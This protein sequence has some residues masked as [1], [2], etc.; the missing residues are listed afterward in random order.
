MRSTQF[1]AA[2]L[3]IDKAIEEIKLNTKCGYIW[4][5]VKGKKGCIFEL[6]GRN[7]EN[8]LQLKAYIPKFENG[9][10]IMLSNGIIDSD[11]GI[12]E[13]QIE[14]PTK[15]CKLPENFDLVKFLKA[16]DFR[17]YLPKVKSHTR[18]KEYETTYSIE[19]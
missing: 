11:Y 3:S 2:S 1:F 14:Y 5:A 9:E 13:F 8:E 7:Y 18:V 12:T 4:L 6:G 17:T 15:N 10:Y 19:L 16:T